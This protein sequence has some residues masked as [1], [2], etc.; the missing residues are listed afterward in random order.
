MHGVKTKYDHSQCP[1]W[2]LYFLNLTKKVAVVIIN[3]A[4]H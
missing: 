2:L 1:S 3:A 4:E